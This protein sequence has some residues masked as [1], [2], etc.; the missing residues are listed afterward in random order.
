M[1]QISRKQYSD[2]QRSAKTINT[3]N[4]QIADLQAH[5]QFL[6]R[7]GNTDELEKLS[8][9]MTDFLAEVESSYITTLN[10][11]SDE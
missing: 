7:V 9:K 6:H 1:T 10:N 11:E 4:H 3:L 5:I 2:Y 8:T